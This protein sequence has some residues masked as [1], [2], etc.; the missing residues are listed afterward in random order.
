MSPRGRGSG[1]APPNAIVMHVDMDA[2]YASVELRRRREL[3]GAAV[4]VGGPPRGVV[5]SATYEA[6]ARG[7]RSGMP[8]TAAKRLAPHATF[9]VPDFDSDRAVSRA[10]VAVFPSVSSIVES[11]SIDEGFL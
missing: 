9:L 3:R 11:A 5:L 6:R 2:F 7:V 8:S 4:S 10:I 1:H